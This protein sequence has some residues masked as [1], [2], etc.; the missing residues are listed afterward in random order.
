MKDQI[1][2]MRDPAAARPRYLLLDR[3]RSHAY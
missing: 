2:R 1:V 3:F